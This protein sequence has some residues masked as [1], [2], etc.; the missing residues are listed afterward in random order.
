MAEFLDGVS[1]PQVCDRVS[2][3]AGLSGEHS[4]HL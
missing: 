2:V 4:F 1:C 3:P